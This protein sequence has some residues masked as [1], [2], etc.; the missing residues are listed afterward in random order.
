MKPKNLASLHPAV[1]RAGFS[2]LALWAVFVT[3]SPAAV[4]MAWNATPTTTLSSGT[5]TL[6]NLTVSS[7]EWLV[8]PIAGYSGT[9]APT[10]TWTVGTNVQNLVLEEFTA[11]GAGTF[12]V[13]AGLFYLSNSAAGTGNLTVTWGGVYDNAV[14]G[15]YGLSNVAGIGGN[16]TGSATGDPGARSVLPTVSLTLSGAPDSLVL[17]SLNVRN[18]GGNSYAGTPQDG[19]TVLHTNLLGSASRVYFDSFDPASN[20]AID[21]NYSA[22]ANSSANRYVYSA[23]EFLAVPKPATLVLVLGGLGLLALLRRNRR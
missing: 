1:L 14:T 20:G 17:G 5:Q 21:L 16:G 12:E 11:L 2:A 9:A 19:Q 8:A 6:S 13:A 23:V 18:N 15:A 7:G 10:A 4:V 22:L 3:D